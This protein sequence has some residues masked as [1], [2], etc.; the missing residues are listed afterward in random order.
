MRILRR[1]LKQH[2]L[3]IQRAA[4]ILVAGVRGL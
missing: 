4:R 3:A 1:Q 2:P